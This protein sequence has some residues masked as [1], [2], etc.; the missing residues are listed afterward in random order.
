MCDTHFHRL[1]ESQSTNL[2]C[3]LI[4]GRRMFDRVRQR[5]TRD[6][7]FS[8][9]DTVFYIELIPTEYLVHVGPEMKEIKL[10]MML[11]SSS[12]VLFWDCSHAPFVVILLIELLLLLAM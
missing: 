6:W 11:P 1:T 12:C 10:Y 5:P 4:A 9:A 3:T 2:T 8:L 7:N